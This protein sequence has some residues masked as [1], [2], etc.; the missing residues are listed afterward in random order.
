M[1]KITNIDNR[2]DNLKKQKLKLQTQKAILFTREA[3]KIFENSFAP[4]IALAV[5]SEW[6]TA[7]EAKKKEWTV[8]SR[9]FRIY[10]SQNARP[11]A[12][13]PHSA[14]DKK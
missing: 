7:T 10:P 4:E 14:V 2:I 6:A 1:D 5:L 3:E 8:R 13:A 11:K 12:E 9:S